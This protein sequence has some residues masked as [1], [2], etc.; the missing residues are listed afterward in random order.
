[1]ADTT[2]GQ[3]D[4][5]PKTVEPQ[6]DLDQVGLAEL[7]KNTLGREEQPEPQP[8]DAENES[9]ESEPSEETSVGAEEESGNDL[10]QTETTDAEAEP[11][12]EEVE[13]DA[14]E[15]GLPA[16]IQES[17]NKRIGKE[18]KKR[19]ALKEE[20]EAEITELKQKLKDAETRATEGDDKFTPVKTEAN[21]FANLET[22]EDVQKELL[23][24]EQTLEWAEDHPEGAYLETEGSEQEFT[25]EDVK[26][27]RR[28]AARAIR[29]QL[30]EQLGY[31]QAVQHLEP[32][33][34]EAFPWWKDQS[35]SEYQGAMAILR[36]MPD[37]ARF[38]DYKFVVGDYIKGRALRESSPKAK[39]KAK[40]VKKAQL[41]PTSS[42][43]Q[44][45]PVNQ[46][47]A[48]SASANKAFRET[49][50][51]DELANVIKLD[52]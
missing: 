30:P 9:E 24:A 20:A 3:T 21:P 34:L 46:A 19:K 10:S 32:Q 49:G 39:A 17:V 37:L 8:T 35:S 50:G 51:V 2:E 6:E 27:I 23:R 14:D 38:P 45:A 29:R 42:A 41:Q 11:A 7:L 13:E 15:G 1:M 44:P 52:L 12:A 18:V 26:E 25:A 22:V 48:R 33:V 40:G 43:E 16:D 28:N 36:Q 4:S 5:P 47:A 31:I